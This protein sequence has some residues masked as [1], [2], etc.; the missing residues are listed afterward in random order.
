MG[1]GAEAT[2][3]KLAPAAQSSANVISQE[4]LVI[5]RGGSQTINALTPKLKDAGTLSFRN[6]LSNPLQQNLA[7]LKPGE[8]YFGVDVSKLPAGSVVFDGKVGSLHTPPGHVSVLV[9]KFAITPEQ[10]INAIV[11]VGR[12]PK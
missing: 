10:I 5:Y 7:V 6:S 8:K 9:D 2:A 1:A 12:F 11:D 3:V 4:C